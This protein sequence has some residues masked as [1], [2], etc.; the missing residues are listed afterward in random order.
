MHIY[1]YYTCTI[2]QAIQFYIN[3]MV[4]VEVDTVQQVLDCCKTYQEHNPSRLEY[5][6]IRKYLIC[7]IFKDL[8]FCIFMLYIVR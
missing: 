4:K 8:Y 3:A 5:V 6:S 7:N 2:V 1:A